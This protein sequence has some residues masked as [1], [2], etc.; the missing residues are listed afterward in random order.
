MRGL[1]SALAKQ[2]TS[3]ILVLVILIVLAWF[4]GESAGFSKKARLAAVAGCVV[5]GVALVAAQKVQAIQGALQIENKLKEQGQ[6]QIQGA[7]PDLRPEVQAVQ[8]QLDEA[9]QALKGSRMGKGALYALP[10]YM[11]IGPPGSGKSTAL[12][13]S[14]LNFPRVSQGRKGVR[15]V[16]GTRNCDWWF[17]DEGILLD[18]AGRYTTEIDDRDEWL[19]FLEMIKRARKRKPINGAIV[20]VSVSDLLNATEEELEAHAKNIRDRIDELTKTLEIVFPVYLLFTK[21]DLLQGFIEFFEDFGRGDRAQV[22]G[23]TL[24]FSAPPAKSYRETFDDECRKLY[25]SLSS[26]RLA[27][28]AGER[29]S[30]KKQNIYLFPLQ[31]SMTLRRL[32]DFVSALFRPNPFQETSILRGFYFTSGTQEGT[33]IDQVIRSLS[34][35]FGLKEEGG[36]LATQAVDK[37]SYFINHLFT[38]IVFP[39]QNLARTSLRIQRRRRVF[40]YATLAGSVAGALLLLAGLTAS[41]FGNRTLARATAEAVEGAR[42]VNWAAP[43][44][45]AAALQTLEKLRSRLERID[46]YDRGAPSRPLTLGLGLYQGDALLGATRKTYLAAVRD[47]LVRPSIDS[48][49]AR[50]NELHDSPKPE[51]R[52]YDLLVDLLA[53]YKMMTGELPVGGDRERKLIVGV[54]A[55]EGRW[56]ARLGG[57][58]GPAAEAQLQ[59]LASQLEAGRGGEALVSPNLGL[60]SKVDRYIKFIGKDRYLEERYKEVETRYRT[61]AGTVTVETYA[62]A[63]SGTA[64]LLKS[65]YALSSMFTEQGRK[66]IV[67]NEIRSR[68]KALTDYF[69]QMGITKTPEAIAQELSS[70]Y[71]RRY[72]SEWE[73]F[74]RSIQLEPFPNLKGAVDRIKALTADDSPYY[75]LLAGIFRDQDPRGVTAEFDKSRVRNALQVL[76]ALQ[77]RLE[78]FLA[79][80]PENRRIVP[81]ERLPRVK[82]LQSDL[83]TARQSL[84]AA[85]VGGGDDQK[86]LLRQ[87]IYEAWRAVAREARQELEKRLEEEVTGRLKAKLKGKYPFDEAADEAAPLDEFSKLFCPSGRFWAFQRLVDELRKLSFEVVDSKSQIKTDEPLILVSHEFDRAVE[88]AR[89]FRSLY[90]TDVADKIALRF[91]A[92]LQPGSGRITGVKLDV[93]DDGFIHDREPR[94]T[95]SMVWTEDSKTKGAKL[96]IQLAG[97]TDWTVMAEAPGD[98]GLVRMIGASRP[99]VQEKKYLCSWEKEIDYQGAKDKY[100]ALLTLDLKDAAAVNPFRKGFFSEFVCPE[101]VAP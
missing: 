5:A 87:V 37:K 70:I 49:S 94:Y 22:W 24:P 39:D 10:W 93:G 55:S 47:F 85:L 51:A 73:L 81:P 77:S 64:S 35:A 18:T 2:G 57:T 13:E 11:I 61:E 29:P 23:C 32:G 95:K 48:L 90:D 76:Y 12:Q 4:G 82:E 31:F 38:K 78:K 80:A 42:A 56:G 63:K 72:K 27:T 44:D 66:S 89:E 1:L 34:Q 65:D 30:T 75:P 28:L 45:P 46:Q 100:K 19:A 53:V 16:G 58:P 99:Q 8:Q 26:Q 50:M 21:C 59:F 71:E 43:P 79:E 68:S 86:L 98:W 15:G 74:L 97:A 83:V 33:P 62:P 25:S 17:T 9:I 52:L 96:S 92:T 101:K 40:H 91:S 36:S 84:D 67:E 3:V 69:T 60:I 41:Y 6:E 14:G 88:K 7:R 54:L 20:A